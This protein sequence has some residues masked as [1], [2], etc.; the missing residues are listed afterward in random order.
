MMAEH[1]AAS[2]VTHE[3]GAA[4]IQAPS[5]GSPRI[6][7]VEH[8][9]S[10]AEMLLAFLKGE[11]Y[12]LSLASSPEQALEHMSEQTFHLVLTDLFAESPRRS[13]AQARRLRRYSL[14]APVGVMTGWQVSAEAA[15]RQ[16]FAFLLQKPFDLD[17]LLAEIDASLHQPL[18]P[19]QARQFQTLGRFMEALRAR[20]REALG[21][22]ITEDFT[23]HP[24]LRR[25][26]STASRVR[27]MAALIAYLQE[28]L[29]RY[30]GVSFDEVLFYPRPKGWAMRYSSHWTIPDGT[31]QNLAGALLI[32]FRGEQ[33]HRVGIQWNDQPLPRL[34]GEPQ[35]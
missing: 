9:Q 32:H 34:L 31:R 24:P 25:L 15:R 23:Y 13:F 16:G 19:E 6:L 27:G 2:G 35:G 3:S 21:P 20:N 30:Q 26:A 1:E 4:L 12:E 33:I 18:T 14:L 11:G 29:T 5:P 7:I 10:V 8:D 17:L 28:S 22:L